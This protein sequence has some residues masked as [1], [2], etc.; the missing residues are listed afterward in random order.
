MSTDDI[1]RINL[2]QAICLRPRMYTQN[3][4]LA[5]VYELLTDDSARQPIAGNRTKPSVTATL[6]WLR[7][8]A[9]DPARIVEEMLELHGTDESALRAICEFAATLSPE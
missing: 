3:G 5:E 2:V 1:Q 6:Q 8:N 4:T 9:S 7:E